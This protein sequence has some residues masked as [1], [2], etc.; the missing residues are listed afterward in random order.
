MDRL[1]GPVI[2]LAVGLGMGFL[3]TLLSAEK[4]L[5]FRPHLITIPCAFS[6]YFLG[7]AKLFKDK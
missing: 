4:L 7:E 6:S 3:F 5:G 2:C 1:K